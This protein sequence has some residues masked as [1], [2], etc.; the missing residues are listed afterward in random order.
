M[1]L[2]SCQPKV[3]V[4]SRESKRLRALARANYGIELSAQRADALADELTRLDGITRGVLSTS[5]FDGEPGASFRRLLVQLAGEGATRETSTPGVQH[6]FPDRELSELSLV[7]AAEGI[8]SG[9]FSSLELTEAC[10]ARIERAQPLLNCFISCDADDARDQ[11]RH[12]DA[13]GAKGLLA[14][15]PLAHK[16]MFYRKGRISTCGSKIFRNVEADVTATVLRRLDAAGALDIG[17]LNMSEFAA[18]ATGHN[19]HYGDCE[20]PWKRGYVPG[21]SSSGSAAAVAARLIYA[22]LGSDTGGSVRLPAYFCGLAGLRPT[23]GRVSRFGAMARSWSADAI[24][25]L[26]REVRDIARITGIIAGADSNDPTCET[27]PVP[28]Y[29]AGI[30]ASIKGLK[31]GRPAG[32]FSDNLAEPQR[33]ALDASLDV[34]RG[35]G[36]E[37]VEVVMADLTPAFAAAQILLKTEATALHQQWMIERP[38]DYALGIRTEMEAG[39][40]IPAARYIAALRKRGEILAEFARNVFSRVEV[41]H[42]P[43][44]EYPTPSLAESNPDSAENAAHIMATFGR[45]TRPISYLGLPAL[46]VPCGFTDNELPIGFQLVGRPFAEA[47]LFNIGHL[48]QRQT[49]WHR[50]APTLGL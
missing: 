33:A 22:A 34:L 31:I 23:Y 14:G 32:F 16:D 28:N 24:G 39:L 36:A 43:V 9:N 1:R 7:E 25:P 8:R 11:A 5:D 6:H 3:S 50:R 30:E 40:F 15:V 2:W 18:G 10:L 13:C 19:E 46:S 17:T 20:N 38:D 12:A 45:C 42:T 47:T 4:V 29:E 26:A 27:L 44:Y 49:D 21:G 48:Y 37:I 35:L 41:L